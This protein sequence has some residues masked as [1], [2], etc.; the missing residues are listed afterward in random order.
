MKRYALVCCDNEGNIDLTLHK[1]YQSARTAMID[2]V[3][4]VY[5]SI[6]QE[7]WNGYER[8]IESDSYE[9]LD[10]FQFQF[11]SIYEGFASVGHR[12][13]PPV[14]WRIFDLSEMA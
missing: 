14:N 1:D 7:K 3:K 5:E 4:A 6:Y 11:V 13:L 10:R 2:A 9:L 8:A 12:N